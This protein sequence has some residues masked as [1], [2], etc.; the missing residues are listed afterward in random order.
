[1]HMRYTARE[2][3]DKLKADAIQTL[4]ELI[5]PIADVSQEGPLF[6]LFSAK[7]EF[8]SEWHQFLHPKDTEDSHK[9]D[10]AI[11]PNRF[12]LEFKD[13]T[14]A[15][16]RVELFLQ[17]K[18]IKDAEK[19]K[20]TNTPLK[21]AVGTPLGDY[22]AGNTPLELNI[23]L[24]KQLTVKGS[25]NSDVNDFSGMPHA[26]MKA[27]HQIK[28]GDMWQVTA[29]S[30]AVGQ[31]KESLRKIVTVKDQ[32][33]QQVPR[34]RLQAEAIDDLIVVCHYSVQ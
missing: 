34:H 3:G 22:A 19:Y 15:N 16:R 23:I 11:T 33:G 2:G 17:F 13:K 8:S 21:H 14:L 28:P 31:I 26:V 9:L 32:E 27:S 18:D 10:L 30:D 5:K 25:L 1:M 7:Q 12:P 6:R 29:T 4:E 20:A 24:S